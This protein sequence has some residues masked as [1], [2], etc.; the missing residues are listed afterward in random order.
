MSS[1]E[2][3][4][5]FPEWWVIERVV[6]PLLTTLQKRQEFREALKTRAVDAPLKFGCESPIR[7]NWEQNRR[8]QRRRSCA[9]WQVFS[10]DQEPAREPGRRVSFHGQSSF[11]E[12]GHFRVL[13][14]ASRSPMA[15]ALPVELAAF[16]GL[17]MLR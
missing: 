7:R 11:V 3:R 10:G 1:I 17:E 9:Y 15:M 6:S 4:P 2:I 16:H 12:A 5:R 14:N 13:T 8:L